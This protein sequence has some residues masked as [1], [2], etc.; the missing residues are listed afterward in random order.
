MELVKDRREG[1]ATGAAAA[2]VEYDQ[3]TGAPIQKSKMR[4]QDVAGSIRTDRQ[5]L[6]MAELQLLFQVRTR[7]WAKWWMFG[8]RRTDVLQL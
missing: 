7:P 6:R 2:A 5:E 3:H 1:R 4:Q 8:A